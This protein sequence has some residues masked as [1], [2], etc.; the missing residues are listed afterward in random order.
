MEEQ[1]GSGVRGARLVRKASP[2]ARVASVGQHGR[3]RGGSASYVP[4]VVCLWFC[5]LIKII[6]T[7]NTVFDVNLLGNGCAL[8]NLVVLTYLISSDHKVKSCE[9]TSNQK[10][11][12]E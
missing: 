5:F 12:Q 10:F 7:L 6:I 9:K 11:N 3:A 1:H 2:K 4:E 8:Y